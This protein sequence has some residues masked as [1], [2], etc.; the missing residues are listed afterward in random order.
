MT[1]LFRPLGQASST[2]TSQSLPD[3]TEG[4]PPPARDGRQAA[5]PGILIEWDP[6]NIPEALDRLISAHPESF[7]GPDALP[8][9]P[10]PFRMSVRSADVPPPILLHP[11]LQ[12]AQAGFIREQARGVPVGAGN[13]NY[14]D[15]YAKLEVAVAITHLRVL[16]GERS[17][18]TLKAVAEGLDLPWLRSFVSFRHECPGHAVLRMTP[19]ETVRA[20]RETNEAVDRAVDPTGPVADTVAV[21]R[22]LRE[23]FPGDRGILLAVC[24]QLI[25]LDP[26]QAMVTPAGCLHTYLSGQALV[27]MSIS[28]NSLK[29]GLTKDYVDVG[30]LQQ[31]LSEVQPA[32][33][34][35]PVVAVDDFQKRIPLWSEDLQLGHAVLGN[36]PRS[37]ELGRFSVVLAALGD[38]EITVGDATTPIAQGSRVLYLGD[39]TSAVVRG[40][41]QLFI[42]SR[43]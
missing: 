40:P 30:E 11:S 25:E 32:P 1:A 15:C 36:T 35:L 8:Q 4:R 19:D 33:A 39:P 41:A 7:T 13:R 22:R 2:C 3:G 21:V 23:L 5:A 17:P 6:A 31:L 28:E 43:T 29:V 14:K 16:A 12:Q 20:L 27:L 10:V 24:M 42:A 37:I 38:A 26:G 18:A 34:P 9:R